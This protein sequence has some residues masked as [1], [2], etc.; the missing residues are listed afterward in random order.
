M[1]W[2]TQSFV[3]LFTG[4]YRPRWI[5]CGPIV[6]SVF[7]VWHNIDRVF[8]FFFHLNFFFKCLAIILKKNVL[9]RGWNLFAADLQ[10][11]CALLP[12]SY[13]CAF[14]VK[15]LERLPLASLG[16]KKYSICFLQTMSDI[17][18]I[19]IVSEAKAI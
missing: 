7:S 4:I 13:Q 18:G 10:T 9:W 19:Y 2:K 6:H 11:L 12:S 16:L 15:S 14:D 1:E 8:F 17:P 5:G 3:L